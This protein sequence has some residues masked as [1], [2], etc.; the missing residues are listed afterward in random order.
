MLTYALQAVFD[1]IPTDFGIG[2]V[3]GN[4][5]TGKSVFLRRFFGECP[6]VSWR[7]DDAGTQFTCF[8]CT[9]VQNTDV[10]LKPMQ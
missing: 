5:A 9:K 4:S 1:R 10:S 3:V 2:L 8:T 7:E 6:P